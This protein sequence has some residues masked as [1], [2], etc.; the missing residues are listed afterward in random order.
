MKI[1]ACVAL[2]L[3]MAVVAGSQ[4]AWRP[5]TWYL[6]AM[7]TGGTYSISSSDMSAW[8]PIYWVMASMPTGG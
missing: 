8:K 3:V 1:L 7:P 5:T 6:A 4:E 2:L